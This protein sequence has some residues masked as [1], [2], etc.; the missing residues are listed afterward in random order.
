MS[1]MT[2]HSLPQVPHDAAHKSFFSFPEVVQSLILGFIPGKWVS[3]L[4]F[5]SLEKV[6]GHFV[7]D[8][9]RLRYSDL[10]WRVKSK[11]GAWH[12]I[13]FLLE[14]QQEIDPWMA[15]RIMT[16]VGL[17]YQDLIKAKII[18]KSDPLPLV[19]PLV[20]YTGRTSWSAPLDVG[21]MLAPVPSDLQKFCPRVPYFLLE[22]AKFTEEELDRENIASQLI[23]MENIAPARMAEPVQ[24]LAGM[25]KAKRFMAL[26]DTIVEWLRRSF[27]NR[28]GFQWSAMEGLKLEE[29]SNMLTLS[30]NL[31]EW[32]RK[33]EEKGIQQGIQQ[34]IQKGMLK[35]RI[36]VLSN[37]LTERFGA[38]IAAVCAAERLRNASSRQ[39][40]IWLKRIL[41]AKTVNEVFDEKD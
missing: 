13:Y 18:K 38:K 23:R 27:E 36:E 31:D 3:R 1:I 33:F 2:K 30:Q 25:L 39:I 40:D 20:Y 10:V 32:E 37:L 29:V 5:K 8:D 9:L 34:G 41:T 14:F 21:E 28:P 11:D 15:V 24:S 12:Y 22:T 16:Y 4:N 7:S 26:K 19:F 35:A 6:S 17:L